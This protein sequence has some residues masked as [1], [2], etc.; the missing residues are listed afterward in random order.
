MSVLEAAEAYLEEYLPCIEEETHE[1]R[2]IIPEI[3]LPLA[4]SSIPGRTSERRVLD[5]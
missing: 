1:G 2:P 5:T 4:A 3:S